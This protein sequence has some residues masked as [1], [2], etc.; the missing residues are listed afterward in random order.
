MNSTV[1]TS[2]SGDG[3]L[4]AAVQRSDP[5]AIVGRGD[6]SL[7]AEEEG[8]ILGQKSSTC[9]VALGMDSVAVGRPNYL[10]RVVHPGLT[11]RFAAHHSPQ[12]SEPS[13]VCTGQ[14]EGRW[15]FG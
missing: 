2:S 1:W 8:L 10:L 13:C 11:A 4:T 12:G 5:E 6:I 9:S 3:R 14:C 15:V 7:L